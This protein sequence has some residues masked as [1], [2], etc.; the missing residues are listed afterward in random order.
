MRHYRQSQ[1]GQALG[2]H[3]RGQAEYEAL[4]VRHQTVSSMIKQP[5]HDAH[6]GASLS[7]PR[8]FK[9][10][11]RKPLWVDYLDAFD[12]VGPLYAISLLL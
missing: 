1:E 3:E 6:S 8:R 10:H 12:L 4:S 9:M 2:D 5:L 7:S 11:V